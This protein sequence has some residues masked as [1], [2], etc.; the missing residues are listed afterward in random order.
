MSKQSIR[1]W[2]L[3][4]LILLI[5]SAG[6]LPLAWSSP[7]TASTTPQVAVLFGD[8]LT[9]ESNWKLQEAFGRQVGWTAYEHSFPGTALCD[10][11]GWIPQ[12]LATY[13]PTVVAIET[14][15]NYTRPC[16]LDSNG[17]QVG[18]GSAAFYAKYRADLNTA[19]AEITATGA[20]VVFVVAP[21][22]LDPTWNSAVIGLQT[23]AKQ[24]LG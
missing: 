21:P 14:A 11:L 9:W 7:A 5:G 23:I 13:H 4:G 2:L 8:S 3:R 24:I 15:G 1:C 17:Q 10:W 12:D 6:L 19:F 18:Q 16:M 22:M 20:K